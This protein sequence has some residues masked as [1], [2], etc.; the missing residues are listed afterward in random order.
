MLL[1]ENADR[2]VTVHFSEKQIWE[3]V[4][5]PLS[6]FDVRGQSSGQ[7]EFLPNCSERSNIKQALIGC[8]TIMVTECDVRCFGGSSTDGAISDL[9]IG[10]GSFTA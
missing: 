3:G 9:K 1:E 5:P 10:A 7:S 2:E 6:F 8:K 4:Y